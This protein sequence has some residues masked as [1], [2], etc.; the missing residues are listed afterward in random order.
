MAVEGITEAAVEMPGPLAPARNLSIRRYLGRNSFSSSSSNSN[1]VDAREPEDPEALAGRDRLITS[2]TPKTLF[3]NHKLNIL[4]LN[5]QSL[6]PEG[7]GNGTD[8]V[9]VVMG[10]R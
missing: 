10:G 4:H 5:S 9:G 1:L 2:P 3:R 6:L 7:L 8:G